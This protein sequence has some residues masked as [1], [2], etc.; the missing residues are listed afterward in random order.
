MLRKRV[1]DPKFRELYANRPSSLLS[2]ME[3][4]LPHT[5]R[6][7]WGYAV[8]KSFEFYPLGG[9]EEEVLGRIRKDY[10][11]QPL[12]T[13]VLAPPGKRPQVSGALHVLEERG[14]IRLKTIPQRGKRRIFVAEVF[15]E[16]TKTW[17]KA[18]LP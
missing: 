18:R 1:G 8:L 2:D 17:K 3:V 9:V 7:K 14:A 10:E 13:G 16:K 15:D 11:K 6:A 12:H 4:N 5:T